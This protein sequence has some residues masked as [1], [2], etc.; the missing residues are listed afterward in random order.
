[1]GLDNLTG[2]FGDTSNSTLYV[3]LSLYVPYF[4]SAVEVRPELY[5][6]DKL[7]LQMVTK[8]R[9]LLVI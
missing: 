7:R 8:C 3:I 9:K 2:C 4:L 5:Y 6:F 1:V